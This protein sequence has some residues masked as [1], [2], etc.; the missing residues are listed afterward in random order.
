MSIKYGT[1]EVNG[2]SYD[3]IVDWLPKTG[4]YVCTVFHRFVSLKKCTKR[5]VAFRTYPKNDF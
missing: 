5:P 4:E 1:V 3:Y 2:K